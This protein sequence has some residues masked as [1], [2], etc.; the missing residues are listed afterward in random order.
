MS[1]NTSTASAVVTE[2]LPERPGLR[3]VGAVF[4]APTS[5][6]SRVEDTGTY[7]W[8]LLVLLAALTVLGWVEIRTGLIDRVVD[9]GTEQSLAELEKQQLDL[10]DRVAFKDEMDNIRKQGEFTKLIRRLG[11][12]VIAP[13]SALTSFLLISSVLYAAVALTGRKPEYH[14]LM[15]ICIYAG[16]ISLVGQILRVVMMIIYRTTQVDT[17]L[18]MLSPVGKPSPWGAID[19]FRIWFW[20]VICLGLCVTQQLSRKAAIISCSFMFLVG[21]GARVGLS[22][23]MP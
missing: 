6:F 21:A 12:V 13:V 11:A 23:V 7:G 4:L 9:L 8:T 15:T 16:F 1:S 18:A 17:S 3:D 19:P 14:T 2:H 22:Y 10:I 20:I 5:L